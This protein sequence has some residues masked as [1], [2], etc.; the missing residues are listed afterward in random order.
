VCSNEQETLAYL[1]MHSPQ[2][3]FVHFLGD[4]QRTINFISQIYAKDPTIRIFYLTGYTRDIVRMEAIEAGAHMVVTLP[5]DIFSDPFTELLTKAYEQSME[6]KQAAHKSLDVFVLMP[7]AKEFD[8]LY[9]LAIKD[10]LQG[11]GF[12][13]E[14][15]DEIQFTGRIVDKVYEKLRAARMIIADIT[16]KNPNVFLEIGYA[17]ALHKTVI[18]LTQDNEDIPFD[19]QAEKCIFYEGSL[20]R[21]REELINTVRVLTES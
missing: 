13:C 16:G 8:D 2:V 20:T 15:G 4:M 7:F 14:R 6:L 17:Y 12:T 18:L 3:A 1:D 19:L 5:V 10:P 21:L 11:M 9:R